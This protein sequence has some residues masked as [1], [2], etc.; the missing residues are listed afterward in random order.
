MKSV[1]HGAESKAQKH[2]EFNHFSRA[3]NFRLAR[4]KRVRIA[5]GCW[6]GEGVVMGGMQMSQMRHIKL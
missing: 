5:G 6:V 1:L 2:P 4:K 3:G